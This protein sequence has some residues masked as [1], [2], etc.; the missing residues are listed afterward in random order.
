MEAV[1][2]RQRRLRAGSAGW[3]KGALDVEGGCGWQARCDG[4]CV[5]LSFDHW[6]HPYRHHHALTPLCT[7]KTHD[8][9]P[10]RSAWAGHRTRPPSSSAPA[11]TAPSAPG[12]SGAFWRSCFQGP[13]SF[14]HP[15]GIYTCRVHHAI[16]NTRQSVTQTNP[17]PPTTT[18]TPRPPSGRSGPTARPAPPSPSP[19]SRP[20]CWRRRA[21][22][23]WCGSGTA[24]YVLTD[25]CAPLGL[26]FYFVHVGVGA[27]AASAQN[28][29]RP[30][31]YPHNVTRKRTNRNTTEQ[32]RGGAR[33]P[34][35]EG[36]GSRQALRPQLL[37][38]VRF[39]FLI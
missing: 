12:T 11:T 23:R 9:R 8:G 20:G 3:L 26:N 35:R 4:S 13:H 31:T 37:P 6:T 14:V 32:P 28:R 25:V 18:A 17:H 22:T 33:G 2:P 27:R 34:G 38:Q 36:H 10:T 1:R 19:R 29:H 39:L 15:S 5:R 16:Q 21:W 24:R 30:H 7:I